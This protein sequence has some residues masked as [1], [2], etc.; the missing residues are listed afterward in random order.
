ML[1]KRNTG[2]QALGGWGHADWE[3]NSI[4]TQPVMIITTTPEIM[5]ISDAGIATKN[6]LNF[7]RM[8]SL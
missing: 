5:H 4:G 3:L 7:W 6:L 8:T 1:Q 2:L